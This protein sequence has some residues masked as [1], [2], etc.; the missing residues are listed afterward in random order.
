MCELASMGRLQLPGLDIWNGRQIDARRQ[1]DMKEGE[2]ANIN[3]STMGD[4]NEI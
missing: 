1:H 2:P 3:K 4:V